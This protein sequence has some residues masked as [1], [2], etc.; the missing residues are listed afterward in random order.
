MA[1]DAGGFRDVFRRQRL[2]DAPTTA[3]FT[4]VKDFIPDNPA[5]V[6]IHLACTG[7]IVVPADMPAT[8][9]APAIFN[10][11]NVVGAQTCTATEVGTPAA[12][13]KNE[14]ACLNIAVTPGSTPSCTI[15]NTANTTATF[16]VSKDFIPNNAAP[17]TVHVVCTGGTT[18]PADTAATEA[19]AAV[20]NLT[21][22][23]PGGTTC[24]ATEVTTPA[25]HVKNEADC[26]AV[27]FLP[28]APAV[29]RLPT[30]WR[31]R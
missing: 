8:E 30:P 26:A 5:P 25:G 22:V 13:V 10:L 21:T 16:T 27:W 9:V 12:H 6:T 7:G 17:V 28:A 15:T 19:A 4:V 1:A 23:P 24:T 29:A 3:T 18:V 11:T 20:F 31:R 2:V 14:A